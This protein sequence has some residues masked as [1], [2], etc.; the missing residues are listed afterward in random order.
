MA[1][2]IHEISEKA[3]GLH[4]L[5]GSGMDQEEE[6]VFATRHEDAHKHARGLDLNNATKDKTKMMM[7]LGLMRTL[8][9]DRDFNR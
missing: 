1:F 5:G 2:R 8:L 3:E 6:G 4:I 9:E 7:H